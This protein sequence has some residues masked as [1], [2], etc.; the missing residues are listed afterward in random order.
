MYGILRPI[1]QSGPVLI[2]TLDAVLSTTLLGGST[3]FT[4]RRVTFVESRAVILTVHAIFELA[5]SQ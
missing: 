2:G 1:F 5:L 4:H 3:A